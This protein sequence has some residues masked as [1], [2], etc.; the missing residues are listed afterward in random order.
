MMAPSRSLTVF[1]PAHN[2]AENL[3]GA[4]AD[5]VAA[6]RDTIPDY[7]VILVDDGST[8]GTA[9]AAARLAAG[10]PRIH[11]IHHA[12][13]RGLAAG[14]RAALRRATGQYFAF[15]PGDREVSAAS[16]R[17]IFQ[18]VGSA[19]LVIPYHANPGARALHRRLMTCVCTT[20]LNVLLDR[21]LRYYQGPTVYPTEVAKAV[22]GRSGG[23][24]FLTE[25]LVQALD[26]GCSYI[27]VPLMHQERAFGKSKAVSLSNVGEALGVIIGAWWRLRVR[28]V[29]RRGRPAGSMG[30]CEEHSRS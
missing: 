4:V 17:A 12:C 13:R 5:I 6:A 11:V 15:L 26:S 3:E 30:G 27:E 9:A 20:L 28:R 1:V 18:A 23:F 24:F 19:D 21:R 16:V 10:D 2:E 14:Y 29:G 22:Q 25:M 7:E 8:D